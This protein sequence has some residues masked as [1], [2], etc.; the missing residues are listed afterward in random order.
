MSLKETLESNRRRYEAE[1]VEFLRIPSVSARSEHKG[2]M[3]RCAEWLAAEL[4]RLGVA[5]EILSTPGH[6]VVYG[7]L[8]E[9]GPNAPTVLVYGHYDVQ[10]PE[11]FDEW[12]TPPFEPDIRE[13]RIYARG[14]VDD[15]GQ[16]HLHLK[17]LEAYRA[18]K[19]RLP[20]NV[21]FML[22]GEEE[23]GSANL[24]AFVKAN[25][26]RLAC[27]AC[28]ISDT[29]M[30]SAELPSI[31][32]G[33]R[34][35]VYIEVRLSG[36]K[37]D[38]HSGAYGGAITNPANA[39]AEMIGAL[40]DGD[41]RISTP[42]FYDAVREPGTA[43][44][45]ALA[46]LPTSEANILEQTGA[47]ELGGGESGV[48]F[49]ERIRTRPTLDV[50]GLLSGYTGEG[51]KTIIPAAAM[52]KLSL[53]LVP[54]QDPHEI[55]GA[56]EAQLE[57]LVPPSLT[58]E[59]TRYALGRPW[60]ADPEGPLFRAAAEAVEDVFGRQ[61]LFVRI[62]GSIPIVPMIESELEVPVLLLG[63]ALPGANHHAPNEWLSLEM[64]H[65][66]I[67]TVARLYETMAS[68]SPRRS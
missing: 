45:K 39:L 29:P 21:K 51:S 5:A 9:A 44:K 63:F 12:E 65:R 64:Y 57:S 36:P 37:Q 49:S 3:R 2:D 10:P 14:A 16:I 62:G 40:R 11:P 48:H 13:G 60:Y 59:I 53:R 47:P 17:A 7:E 30:A 6:P 22:E 54:D 34:G 32:T 55:C 33:L 24:D 61:P 23:V 27:D 35:L 25:R 28:V 38:L 1:L 43:E 66:G 46:Q 56:L 31:V 15:K 50:N 52:A 19:G 41:G 4:E 58:L 18:A 8:L 67:E 42:G 26:E 68:T 20:I